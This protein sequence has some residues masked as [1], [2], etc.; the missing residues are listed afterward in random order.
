MIYKSGVYS[1]ADLRKAVDATSGTY[2]SSGAK[3]V[4]RLACKV[5]GSGKADV[6]AGSYECV[7]L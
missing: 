5:S 4:V 6:C 3:W 1:S 7:T 2:E